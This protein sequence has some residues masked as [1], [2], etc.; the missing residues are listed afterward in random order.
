MIPESYNNRRHALI[1][2]MLLQ[3]YFEAL[4]MI[5]GRN[6][7]TIWYVDCFAG[8]WQIDDQDLELKDTSISISIQIMKR[9]Q[10]TLSRVFNRHVTFKAI[11][12]EKNNKA[13][14]RLETYL[15]SLNYS[16]IE[17]YPLK[18]DFYKLRTTIL[19]I[20][21]ERDFTFFFIDPKGWKQVIEIPTLEPLI[22]RANCEFLIN[23]MYLFI[24]RSYS[25]EQFKNHM[26]D[27]FG[28][29]PDDCSL[30]P[31]RREKYL[32]TKYRK[33]LKSIKSTDNEQMRTA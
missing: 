11:Y 16:N 3:K 29:D 27:I 28:T 22:K 9:C 1:K 32:I 24:N 12:V 8:P 21:G 20:I 30:T 33:Y 4:C 31:D 18:G 15:N 26:K 23:F 14:H 2:H 17:T 10:D 19:N 13:F 7:D 25:A 5:I 6:Q